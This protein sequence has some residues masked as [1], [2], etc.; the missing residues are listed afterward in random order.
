MAR[1]SSPRARP[2]GNASAQSDRLRALERQVEELT[3]LV[4]QLSQRRNRDTVP[5]PT[6][7]RVI[8]PDRADT[9]RGRVIDRSIREAIEDVEV[10]IEEI[11]AE[12]IEDVIEVEI[13]E[14]AA[15]EI[16]DIIEVEIEEIT[17]E[18]IEDIIEVEIEEITAE[19]I[20]DVIEVEIEEAE[21]TVRSLL[22]RLIEAEEE[23]KVK[24]KAKTK[25]KSKTKKD[26]TEVI[27]PRK[28]IR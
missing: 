19:E 15:E 1:V 11:I 6:R 20:E 7:V 10:E 12:E 22:E 26:N 25:V 23:E 21:D 8:R 3:R 28:V 9:I 24:E 14:I 18:E 13:E 2:Q 5:E 4:R 27:K 17:A 16:E